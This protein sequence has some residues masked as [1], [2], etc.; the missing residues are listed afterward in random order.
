MLIVVLL[1]APHQSF[2]SD[3]ANLLISVNGSNLHMGLHAVGNVAGDVVI[4]NTGTYGN[5]SVR[6]RT[7]FSN[8]YPKHF[9][10]CFKHR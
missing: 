8:R 6:F 3:E 4:Y 7:E 10:E 2:A 1:I 5:E 9:I